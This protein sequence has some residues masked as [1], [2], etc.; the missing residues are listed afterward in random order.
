MNGKID[1]KG[2]AL[3]LLRSGDERAGTM[4][5]LAVVERLESISNQLAELNAAYAVAEFGFPAGPIDPTDP[6]DPAEEPA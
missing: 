3:S 5:L 1:Y 2:E 4:A 6:R